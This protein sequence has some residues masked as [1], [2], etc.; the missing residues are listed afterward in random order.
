MRI[1]TGILVLMIGCSEAFAAKERSETDLVVEALQ[2]HVRLGSV[3]TSSERD[4]LRAKWDV[5]TT[6]TYQDK[7][8]PFIG[9]LRFT[10]EF[11]DKEKNVYYG[12]TSVKQKEHDTNYGG[13]DDWRFRIPNG[14]LKSLKLTAYAMEFGFETNGTFV[15]VDSKVK[16]A[17]NSDE[18]MARN[19]DP[20][21]KLKVSGIISYT[22]PQDDDE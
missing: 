8:D 6:T 15:V 16:K 12:Q 13:K 9:T 3:T 19:T 1:L 18:I 7:D 2:K 22:Y 5:I 10:C 21:K 4:D 14:D 11:V 17:E 20:D